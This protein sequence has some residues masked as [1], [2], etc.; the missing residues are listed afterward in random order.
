M[1]LSVFIEMTLSAILTVWSPGPNNILLLSTASK[2]GISGNIRFMTGIWSGSLT[3][4]CLSGLFC[5]TL[6]K[7]IPGIQ[8]VMKYFGAAY[9]SILPGRP[10]AGFRPLT[11]SRTKSQPG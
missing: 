6:G 7:I 8:P 11:M 9:D 1:P 3:L 4:M 5:S 10:G 2:Y